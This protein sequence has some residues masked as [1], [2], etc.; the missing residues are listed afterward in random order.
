MAASRVCHSGIPCGFVEV[1]VVLPCVV[2]DGL[3]GGILCLI[4]LIF[5]RIEIN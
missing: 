4:F 2:Y 1:Y 3:K 5:P